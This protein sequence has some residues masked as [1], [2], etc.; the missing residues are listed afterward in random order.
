LGNKGVHIVDFLMPIFCDFALMGTNYLWHG[1][2]KI[3]FYQ[4]LWQQE[5]FDAAK[6]GSFVEPNEENMGEKPYILI[7][8]IG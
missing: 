4:V 8:P 3:T 6:N 2:H 1:G 5:P 7:S